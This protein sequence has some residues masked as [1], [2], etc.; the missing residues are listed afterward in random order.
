MKIYLGSDH[1][2][3]EL[4]ADVIEYIMEKYPEDELF[5]LGCDSA[6]SVDY[7]EYGK[8][9][10]E[11]VVKDEKNSR[12]IVICGS[13]VGIGI[14]AN[15]IKGARCVTANSVELATLG[16]QHNGAQILSM[17][18]RT[19]FMTTWQDVVDAFLTTDIDVSERHE[20][21]RCQLG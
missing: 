8:A 13:G 10:A 7:P 12:G 15:K 16:R 9:V 6:D 5:D 4:K 18:A 3:W 20:R 11:A 21:R 1:G 19:K 14:A 2:G 17:G